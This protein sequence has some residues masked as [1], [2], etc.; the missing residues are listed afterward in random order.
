MLQGSSRQPLAASPL[1]GLPR[2][3]W[4]FSGEGGLLPFLI[5]VMQLTHVFIARKC[6]GTGVHFCIS[7]PHRF[8]MSQPSSVEFS[9]FQIISFFLITFWQFSPKK[10]APMLTEVILGMLCITRT[11]NAVSPFACLLAKYSPPFSCLL[12]RIRNG[13]RR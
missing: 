6:F 4:S 5:Q 7:D 9:N 3:K 10:T 12:F 2:M 8:C 13:A 11:L 1:W